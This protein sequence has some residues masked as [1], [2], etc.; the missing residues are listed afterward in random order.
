[1]TD[2][3]KSKSRIIHAALSVASVIALTT[4]L[5]AAPAMAQTQQARDITIEPMPI[6]DA[7][8]AIADQSG[9]QIVLY[10]NDVNGLT[11]P[12][13][14]GSYTAE[15]ALDTILDGTDLQYRRV[16][17]RT[18]A[19][20]PASRFAEADTSKAIPTSNTPADDETPSEPF[21]MAQLDQEDTR[22]VETVREARN[23]EDE[24]VEDVI[25][26]TGTNIR[27]IAP[28]SS[29][30]LTFDRDD[31]LISGAATAHDFIQLL[32]QNFGG[33]SNADVGGGLPNDANSDFNTVG[34]TLG[35]SVNLRGLGSGS[36]LVLVNSRRVAPTSGIGDFVDVSL[37][38]ASAIER[39]EVLTDGASSIYGADAVAGVVNFILRDDFDGLEAS[40]RYG[41][42]TEGDFDEYRA[43]I[44]GGKNWDSGNALLV[45]EYFDQSDLS[46]QDRRFSQDAAIPNDLL[47]SQERHSVLATISQE[48]SSDLEVFADFS[49]S[50]REA[51]QDFT[52]FDGAIFQSNPMT[53][54]LNFA[55]GGVWN[56]G[57]DWFI[58]FGGAYSEVQSESALRGANEN[59]QVLDSEIWTSDIK[60]SGPL[61]ELSGG[62]VRIAVGGQYRSESFINRDEDDDVIEREAD[63]DVYAVF[64]EVFVPIVGDSNALPLVE[65]L[66]VNISGRFED[67]SD[68]G[69]SANPKFGVLWSPTENLNL[70]SSYSTSFNPPPLG[71]VGAR[72]IVV[73]ALNTSFINQIFGLTA[74]DPSIDDVVVLT[75]SGTSPDL[76][77]ES[78]RS[79]TAGLDFD[80]NWDRHSVTVSATYFDIEFEDRLGSTPTPDGRNIVEAPN[81][82]FVDPGAFPEGA[83]IFMPSAAQINAL[84]DSANVVAAFPGVDPQAAEIINNVPLVRNLAQTDVRGLD[85]GL[86]YSYEFEAGTLLAGID[87]TYLTDF[88]QQESATTARVQQLD[89]L[90]N[91]VSLRMR[92]RLSFVTDSVSANLFVNFTDDYK[93]D[94]SPDADDID[95]WTTVDMSVSYDTGSSDLSGVLDD[96]VF[97]VSVQNLFDEQPPQTPS[98]PSF[99]IFGFDPT[100]ASPLNRFVS[101]EVTKRF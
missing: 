33:G 27:G 83:V 16:N 19:V 58:D 82:A 34:G 69:S 5:A 36:T 30:A 45:Y 50:Q 4:G 8:N 76:D 68:F 11:A 93:V 10:S 12:A 81:I 89:T 48:L 13:L 3:T 37:I 21:R 60:A 101:F 92:S 61:F 20:G 52:A 73:S 6:A 28:D 40:F 26:V 42:A 62:A 88:I 94:T 85:F 57:S 97:R 46:A 64:G 14:D 77:A 74:P 25:V 31:I 90:F 98:V 56:L 18:I 75:A 87:G 96:V 78:S 17:D 35:S 15:Q 24:R 7:V 41:T 95:S 91:P 86:G 22:A 67:F 80:K 59:L 51:I 100:N 2:Q 43:S 29:P 71:R 99:N 65:R 1:M 44:T 23:Q 55:A 47:P 39:V 54:N 70:R 72:D 49:F 66:E 9:T 53:E 84:L 38:P 79:I 32:P 63:R